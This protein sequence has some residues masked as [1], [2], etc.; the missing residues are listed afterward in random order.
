MLPH[1]PNVSKRSSG[2]KQCVW[3]NCRVFWRLGSL[4]TP[5]CTKNRGHVMERRCLARHHIPCKAASTLAWYHEWD[6]PD[7][8]HRTCSGRH[9]VFRRPGPW[10]SLPKARHHRCPLSL[11][12]WCLGWRP[13]LFL[14][15]RPWIPRASTRVPHKHTWGSQRLT[16]SLNPVAVLTSSSPSFKP[17]DEIGTALSQ[18]PDVSWTLARRRAREV[19]SGAPASRAAA[20]HSQHGVSQAF[21]WDRWSVTGGEVVDST[22]SLHAE[23]DMSTDASEVLW[24]R[25]GS[26]L[27]ISFVAPAAEAK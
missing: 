23:R 14:Q 18:D 17:R 26:R 25:W 9:G 1:A 22:C 13:A 2:T 11:A 12:Q 15:A 4:Q 27:W 7:V 21:W 8:C 16:P 10:S 5:P 24:S 20:F 19:S 6:R 3:L